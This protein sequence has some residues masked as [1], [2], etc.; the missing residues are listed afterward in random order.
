MYKFATS[1]DFEE[2][3]KKVNVDKILTNQTDDEIVL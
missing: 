3:S 1:D 2:L